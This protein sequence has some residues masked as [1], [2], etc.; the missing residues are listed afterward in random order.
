MAANERQDELKVGHLPS[1]DGLRGVA[2]LVVVLVHSI[3]GVGVG[4]KILDAIHDT[5][6]SPFFN[7]KV[8]VQVFFVLSGFVLTGSLLRNR[9]IRQLPQFY[10]RRLFRIH[11]PYVFAL[12][13]AWIVSFQYRP[14]RHEISQFGEVL[15]NIRLSVDE[16][17]GFMLFPGGAGMQLP[18]GWTLQIE[19]IFSLLLPVMLWFALRTHVLLLLGLCLIPFWIGPWGHPIFKFSLDF[20][21]G[22]A[23]YLHGD[24]LRAGF[25]RIGN[26]GVWG[27]VLAALVIGGTP[28]YLNWPWLIDGGSRG[29]I[30]LQS[31]GSAGLVAAAAHAPAF[32]R[33][34]VGR[35]CVFLGMISYSVYLLHWP[36]AVLVASVPWPGS[37][38]LMMPLVVALTIPIATVSYYV[39]ERPSVRAGNW[40]CAKLA[41]RSGRVALTS[42]VGSVDR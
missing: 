25:S 21:L 28:L 7:P 13:I 17:L 26:A 15:F 11:P 38:A 6:F 29:S 18:V 30:F 42:R 41:L 24:A 34:F 36:I 1:L 9:S 33:L 19:M 39:V 22:I 4:K 16:L 31:I 12:V 37:D 20:A 5:P 14:V 40:V 2:A 35:R 3:S 27:W 23:I 32:T 8:A 10:V